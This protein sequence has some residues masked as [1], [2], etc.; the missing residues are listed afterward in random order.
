MPRSNGYGVRGCDRRTDRQTDGNVGNIYG[1]KNQRL[2]LFELPSVI[3]QISPFFI[4]VIL[5]CLG[6]IKLLCENE[7]HHF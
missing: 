3:F 1:F 6:M 7:T 2:C 4:F 5:Q